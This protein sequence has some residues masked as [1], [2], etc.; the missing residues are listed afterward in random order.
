MDKPVRLSAVDA[1]FERVIRTRE[2]PPPL[3]KV[4]LNALLTVTSLA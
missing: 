1:R 3:I 4:G 2:T